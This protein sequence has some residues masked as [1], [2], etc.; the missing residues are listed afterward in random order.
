MK[1]ATVSTKGRFTI[2]VELRRKY[3]IQP[4]TCIVFKRVENMV[5]LRPITPAYI[6][7]I[8]GILQN[9]PNEKTMTQQLIEAHTAE[10]ARDEAGI[11]MEFFINPLGNS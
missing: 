6:D 8:R 9:K 7:S 10:V 1:T 3:D 11:G 4:G 5:E 2:P